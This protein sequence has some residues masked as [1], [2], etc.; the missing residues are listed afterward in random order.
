MCQLFSKGNWKQ[1]PSINCTHYIAATVRVISKWLGAVVL[2]GRRKFSNWQKLLQTGNR[3]KC[4]ICRGCRKSEL[5]VSDSP[6]FETKNTNMTLQ[7]D[8]FNLLNAELNSISHLLV[9]LGNLTFMGPCIVYI[10]IPIY[11]HQDATLNNLFISGNCSTYFGWYLHPSS[12]PHTTVSTA[13]GICHKVTAI[14]RYRGRVGTGFNMLWVAY[15]THSTLKPV[16]TLPRKRQIAITMCQMPDV[17]DTALCA[18]D[19]GW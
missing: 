6:N 2:K 11:S 16:P 1:F 12:G 17:V 10:Y 13:A 4:V 14:C 8:Y 5:F 9:L 3:K 18:P 19:D 7:I 15:S